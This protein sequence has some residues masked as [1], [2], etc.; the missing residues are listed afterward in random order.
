[1]DPTSEE[2]DRI[3]RDRR[4]ALVLL[5]LTAAAAYAAPVLLTLSSAYAQGEGG[6]GGDDGHG[7]SGDDD[8]HGSEGDINSGSG[9][10]PEAP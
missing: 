6:D 4:R 3:G 5:G 2:I 9:R 8:D 1:M 7:G 10:P